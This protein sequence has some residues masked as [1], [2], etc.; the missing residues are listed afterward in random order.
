MPRPPARNLLVVPLLLVVLVPAGAATAAGE[1]A[2]P[3]NGAVLSLSRADY[4]RRLQGFWLGQCIANWTGLIT[5]MDKVG[6]P[7][8][9][10]A[11]W[12]GPDQPNL[13][14]GQG[15]SPTI[16]FFLVPSGQAWGADDD[17][18][19]EY[20]YQHLLEQH[21]V[22]ILTAEQIRDGW[23]RHLWSDNFNRA[24]ENF[25]W[26]SNE[27]AYELMRQGL[28]PPATGRP[29]HNPDGEMIDAQLT[30]EIFGLFAP[31]RPDVALAMAALPIA[32]TAHGEAQWAAEFYVVMHALAARVDPAQPRGDQVRW[33]AAQARS[34]LPAGSVVASMYD[35]VR[36]HY[37]A[38]P[39][40]DDWEETRDALHRAYQVEG[41]GGYAYRRP[42]DAAINFGA[43]LV[44]L[45]YG[46]GDLPRTLRIGTLA[47]WDADNPTAT[48]GGLLGFLLG[49]D[50]VEEALGRRDLSD[51]Y[52]I[53]RTRR[54]FPD[55]TPDQEG[56]DSF[57]LM[58][59]RALGVVDRTVTR[60]MGGRRES[61]RDLWLIPLP[62]ETSP[63]AATR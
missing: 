30:T 32:T 20:L 26:V 14:G 53:S 50:G 58:A 22:S 28:L 34:R 44:S 10:D 27:N 63:P 9:T 61:A 60:E 12:G 29:E 43:S 51:T 52:R 57:P 59:E 38:N 19:M 15:L 31:G 17:T 18:D 2:R 23:L 7:F 56:E 5:E 37:E 21:E 13:W 41:R 40:K 46:D 35:F 3:T 11:D 47:G 45:L 16:D 54:S 1:E 8:Y 33:L 6:P 49:R 55:R 4:A 36:A 25:L 62:A 42:F 48:W 39:D 24:G